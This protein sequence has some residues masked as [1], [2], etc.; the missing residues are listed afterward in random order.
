MNPLVGAAKILTRLFAFIGRELVEVRRRPG[1]LVS[2]VFGPF[3]VM[4]VFGL[5]YSGY[6][7]PLPTMLVI[8]PE[9]GLPA[10]A[11]SYQEVAGRFLEIIAVVPEE[12][13]ADA[14][15]FDSLRK[16]LRKGIPVHEMDCHINDAPFATA[17]AQDLLS[18][19]SSARAR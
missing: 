5:G 6:R 1:A 17:M 10:D 9:S 12:A 11:A 15:L 2:L 3:L 19:C 13:Q 7:K 4:A 8:P 16:S 14:A 18:M